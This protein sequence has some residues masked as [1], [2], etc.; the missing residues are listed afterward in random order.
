MG[1]GQFQHVN[2]VPHFDREGHI[3]THESIARKWAMRRGMEDG[4]IPGEV[5]P[6]RG[7][8]GNLFMVGSLIVFG[9]AVPALIV[10]KI[11]N[12]R[13]ATSEKNG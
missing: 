11:I 12:S 10:D 3:R 5:V 13:K 1:P 8:L 6:P 7:T 9:I 4:W 2:D